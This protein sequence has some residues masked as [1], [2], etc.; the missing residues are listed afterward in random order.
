MSLAGSPAPSWFAR[1]NTGPK[2][3]PPFFQ[4]FLASVLSIWVEKKK[5]KR[6]CDAESSGGG[7]Q[8]RRM[9]GS[10]RGAG[11]A[12]LVVTGEDKPGKGAGR[13][14]VA[15]EEDR[16]WYSKNDINDKSYV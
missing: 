10:G 6:N 7:L 8:R 3:P 16:T 14:P 2:P 13:S 15:V 1:L 4:V 11:A 9:G 5:P 12:V